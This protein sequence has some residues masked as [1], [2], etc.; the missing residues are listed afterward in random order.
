MPKKPNLVYVFADQLRYFSCG[1]AGD[2][3]A[4]TPNIDALSRESLDVCECISNHPVCAPYRASLFT[5]KYTT[6]TGM[7]INEIRMNPDHRTFAHC[8][9]DAG[10]TTEYIGKWHM[11]AN[12]KGDHENPKNSFVPKGKDRLGFD[13]F[14]AHYGFHHEYQNEHA[15]YHLDTPEKIYHEGYEPDAQ[16][17]MAIERLKLLKEAG[18]PFALFLSIGTPHDPWSPYNVPAKYYDKFKDVQF[19]LPPNYKPDN[20]PHADGWARFFFDERDHITD[21]MKVYYA[22]VN[23]LDDNVGRLRAALKE[24]DLEDDTIFVFTVDHG[25]MFGAQGR[26]AKNIFYEEA[27]RVPF[28]IRA[29]DLPVTKNHTP[30]GTVDI[31]PT[32]LS[33]MGIP[34]P[35]EVEGRDVSASFKGDENAPTPEGELLMCTGTTADFGDGVEWRAYRTRQYTYAV[36]KSDG[37]ELLFDN[38][39][40]PY[41]TNNLI[42][43]PALSAARDA[44]KTAMYAEMARIGDTF[45]NNSYYEKNWIEDRII[46]RTATVHTAW[47]PSERK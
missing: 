35:E 34:Y 44:L 21:W 31:M 13:G 7:V 3:N 11:Y 10:Y 23:N 38:L 18:D 17:T 14:F 22:M 27:A 43:D 37:Q 26:R 42:D 45:E 2:K 1:Y 30:F 46:K 28:L 6:S 29:K 24:L 47:K 15:Y 5:G 41:Q 36:F 8:L 25:E 40:D 19:S 12:M 4:I 32:L 20:D 33:L 39:H 9:N 16:T